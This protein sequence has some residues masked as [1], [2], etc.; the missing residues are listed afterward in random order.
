MPHA[1]ILVKIE[2]Y[3]YNER[4]NVVT[5]QRLTKAINW[6]RCRYLT[7]SYEVG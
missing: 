6:L 2:K 4:H 1:A 7:N 5:F 3:M